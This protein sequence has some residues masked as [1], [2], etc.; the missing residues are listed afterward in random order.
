MVTGITTASQ[1]VATGGTSTN[2]TISGEVLIIPSSVITGVPTVSINKVT[3]VNTASKNVV[4]SIS[5][6]TAVTAV[7]TAAQTMVTGQPSTKT[8]TGTAATIT[9]S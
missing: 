7:T 5:T 8:F 9:V 4:S 2:I 6:G 1:T 3:A